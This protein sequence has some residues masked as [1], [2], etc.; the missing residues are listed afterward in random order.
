MLYQGDC[1]DWLS[2][3]TMKYDCGFADPPDNLGLKY[4]GLTDNMPEYAYY[5]WL[6]WLIKRMLPTFNV[7][8]LSIYH[9]HLRRTLALIPENYDVR[10]YIWRFRFGQYRETDSPNGY[11]PILR[12]NKPDWQPILVERVQSVREEMGDLRA[13]GQGKIPDD[14]WDFC[15]IQGN[16]Y[17]RRK[18]HPTQHPED[19]YRRIKHMSVPDDGTFVDLFA[20]SGTVFRALTCKVIGIEQSELYCEELAKE[21]NL[22]VKKI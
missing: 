14:V 2:K 18:W 16:N 12:I 5:N 13:T 9:K 10:V 15:R 8:W 1:L 21:H 20:G 7:S 6:D 4:D 19:I 11:R 22:I 3:N 17:E